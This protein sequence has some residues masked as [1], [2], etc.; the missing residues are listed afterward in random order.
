M[1]INRKLM[2]ELIIPPP[3]SPKTF[4]QELITLKYQ[5]SNPNIKMAELTKLKIIIT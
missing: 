2:M 4:L 1:L 3:F 5:K